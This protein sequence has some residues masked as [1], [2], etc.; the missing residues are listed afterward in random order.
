M[1]CT[2]A[3]PVAQLQEITVS[4]FSILL[5]QIRLQSS[6]GSKKTLGHLQS[7]L[8]QLDRKRFDVISCNWAP[9]EAGNSLGKTLE[10]APT[11]SESKKAFF[12]GFRGKRSLA[13][14]LKGKFSTD[15][16]SNCIPGN[17]SPQHV[18]L[19]ECEA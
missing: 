13:N 18:D 5:G 11:H 9:G 4:T 14:P 16:T 6:I 12:Q 3:S 7:Y 1:C 10:N 2:P 19:N 15:C 8:T 17:N